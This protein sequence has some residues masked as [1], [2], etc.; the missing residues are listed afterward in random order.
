MNKELLNIVNDG[1]VEIYLYSFETEHFNVNQ[2]CFKIAPGVNFQVIGESTD[3]IKKHILYKW[4][5]FVVFELKNTML[6]LNDIVKFQK[7]FIIEVSG[8]VLMKGVIIK[9][10]YKEW[11]RI[12][13]PK[14]ET[15]ISFDSETEED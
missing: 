15:D 3:E 12:N 1:Q 5:P 11:I 7:P 9:N 14:P 6:G 13:K 2:R 8:K 4:Q 10:L